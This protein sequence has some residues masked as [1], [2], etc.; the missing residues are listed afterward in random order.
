[1]PTESTCHFPGDCYSQVTTELTLSLLSPGDRS[2]GLAFAPTWNDEHGFNLDKLKHWERC[3][4][5]KSN[6]S[7]LRSFDQAISS[8]FSLFEVLVIIFTHSQVLMECPLY[9]ISAV[10]MG[11][12]LQV[13]HIHCSHRTALGSG[14]AQWTDMMSSLQCPLWWRKTCNGCLMLE[15]AM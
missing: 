15:R 6:S 7:Q 9:G 8:F 13:W 14:P 10:F 11:Y 1:M 4:K 12:P 3:P 2:Q 5:C